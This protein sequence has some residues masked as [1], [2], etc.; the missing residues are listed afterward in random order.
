MVDARGS[1]AAADARAWLRWLAAAPAL[2]RGA[3][4][5]ARA[6]S[7]RWLAEVV[8]MALGVRPSTKATALVDAALVCAADHELNPSTFAAR[9]AASA[10]AGV[11]GALLAALATFSGPAHGAASDR[12]HVLLEEV[13]RPERAVSVL[14][15]WIDRGDDLPGFGHPLYAAGD[16]RANVLLERARAYDPKR[17]AVLDACIDAASLAGVAPP[18]V[19]L[20]LVAVAR[21]LR[22]PPGSASSMFA[23]GRTAGWIAH[24]LEQ[25]EAGFILRPRARFVA[26]PRNG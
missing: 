8:L 6:S 16:P 5:V 21:V 10:G 15:A 25:Q 2:A 23:V 17:M 12:V 1:R 19:D 24:A 4:E 7:R 18:N 9:V 13:G 20:G 11:P 26:A 22:L 14:R 3:E